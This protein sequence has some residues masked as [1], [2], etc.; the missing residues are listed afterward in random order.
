MEVSA[1]DIADGLPLCSR[2]LVSS[3]DRTYVFPLEARLLLSG[4]STPSGLLSSPSSFAGGSI[5][6]FVLILRSLL[7]YAPAAASAE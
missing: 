6:L 1:V 3:T 2:P 7:R 4:L 5:D